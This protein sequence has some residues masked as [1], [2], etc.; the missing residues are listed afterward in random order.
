MP[1]GMMTGVPR[2]MVPVTVTVFSFMIFFLT[3]GVGQT[4]VSR[5]QARASRRLLAR[6]S[7]TRALPGATL[8]QAQFLP[9]TPTG[10][11]APIILAMMYLSEGD[12]GVVF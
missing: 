5:R 4:V 12:E 8:Q 9:P 3:V 2:L 7:A 11:V 10:V 6:F 1:Q